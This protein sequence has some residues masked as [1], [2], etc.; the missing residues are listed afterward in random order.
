M[1]VDVM[2]A[3]LSVRFTLYDIEALE[4]ECPCALVHLIEEEGPSMGTD[5]H[6]RPQTEGP[7]VVLYSSSGGQPGGTVDRFAM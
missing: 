1:I 4:D 2:F 5:F 6:T 7:L 3:E